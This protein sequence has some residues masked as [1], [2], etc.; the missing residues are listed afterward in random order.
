MVVD[1]YSPETTETR[2]VGG[3]GQDEMR[4]AWFMSI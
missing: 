4:D 1:P 3:I 2:Q